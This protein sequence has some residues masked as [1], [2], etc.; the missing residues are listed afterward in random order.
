MDNEHL[1][2][3]PA[4]RHDTGEVRTSAHVRNTLI[5]FAIGAVF[6]GVGALLW[7]ASQVLLLVFAGTL[8][9]ILLQDAGRQLQRLLPVSEKAAMLMV[10]ALALIVLVV[11]VWLLAPRVA[12]EIGQLWDQLPAAWQNLRDYM[13][14]NPVLRHLTRWMPE[15][16]QLMSRAPAVAAQA[17][18]IFTGV[19]GG[20]ADFVVIFFVSVYLALQPQPY[21]RGIIRLVPPRRRAR[22]REVLHE[23]GETLTYWLRGKLLSMLVIGVSTGVGL[24]LLGV[25]LALALGVVAGVLDFI[26]YIGPIL[27]ALPAVLIGFSE[28]LH[29]ALYVVLLFVA[30]Q[31][32]EGYLLLPLVERR[33]VALPPALNVTMQILLGVPF[34]LIGVALATPLTAVLIVLVEMLY[35]QDTLEDPVALPTERH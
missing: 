35:V 5:V 4:G 6:V 14:G 9:A 2:R 10:L 18:N 22:A 33:T 23:L 8:V 20:L 28:G 1:G 17:G 24:Y 7:Q 25:P 32:M 31:N 15:P 29:P 11:G 27:A 3:E 12:D 16:G 21:M 26:P 30:L 34:G 19:L 13:E